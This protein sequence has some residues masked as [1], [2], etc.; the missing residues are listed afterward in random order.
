MESVREGPRKGGHEGLSTAVSLGQQE[1]WCDPRSLASKKDVLHA[2]LL[3]F[4]RS[5]SAQRGG[6]RGS[7]LAVS[8]GTPSS[9][10]TRTSLLCQPSSRAR[11]SKSSLSLGLLLA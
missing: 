11:L 3:A 4:N 9:V 6:G 2:H 10:S 7:R 1:G 8:V 5:T